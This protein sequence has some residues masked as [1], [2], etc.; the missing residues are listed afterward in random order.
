MVS[1]LIAMLAVPGCAPRWRTTTSPADLPA[2]ARSASGEQTPRAAELW[3]QVAQ[4]L[5][6]GARV[7]VE[8]ATGA[9]MKGVLLAAE[10]DAL[11]IKPRTRVPESERR[12]PYASIG[13]LELDASGS[14]VGVG[15]AIAIGIGA[16]AAA[17][18]GLIVL[19]LALVSD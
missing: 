19:S 12:V 3:H 1:V 5:P 6:P 2:V 16:G 9:R 17:F 7:N 4:R 14:G 18:F 13:T 8:L 15:K 11:V 10:N